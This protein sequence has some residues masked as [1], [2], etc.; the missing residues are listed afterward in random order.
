MNT[1]GR[2]TNSKSLT[3]W[4][5]RFDLSDKYENKE[6]NGGERKLT[7]EREKTREGKCFVTLIHSAQQEQHFPTLRLTL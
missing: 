7:N 2:E 4:R 5:G 3:Q 1:V 6:T